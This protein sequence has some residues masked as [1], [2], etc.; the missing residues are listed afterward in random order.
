[1]LYALYV[2]NLKWNCLWIRAFH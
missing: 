1:M 2:Y